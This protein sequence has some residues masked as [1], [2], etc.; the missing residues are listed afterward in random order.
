MKFNVGKISST[1]LLVGFI[2]FLAV[3]CAAF[4]SYEMSG[5]VW[6][7]WYFARIFAKTGQFVIIDRSP[8]YAL[9]LNLFNWLP[10]PVSV[11][12][13]YLVTTS[14]VVAAV[15]AFIRSYL[16]IWL[17]LFGTCLWLPFFQM[18]EPPVQKLALAFG[19]LAISIR[20]DVPTR[21]RIVLSYSLLFLA[22]LFR[23]NYIVAIA[24][25][26]LFDAVT[27]LRS[28]GTASCFAWRPK[29]GSDWPIVL[30]LALYVWFLSSQTTSP[31]SNVWFST[32]TWFP[33]DGKTMANGGATQCFNWVYILQKY[34][35]FKDHDFYFTNKEVF[36]GQTSL[37]GIFKANPW[38]I[39]QI[40]FVN[41]KSLFTVMLLG[42]ELPSFGLVLLDKI[43]K[44][45]MVGAIFYGAFRG[46]RD[47]SARIFIVGCAAM[48]ATTTLDLP[49]TR[50]MFPMIP[51][52]IMAISWYSASFSNL[53]KRHSSTPLGVLKNMGLSL[54]IF[55]FFLLLFKYNSPVASPVG[56]TE[57][58]H[59]WGACISFLGAI[60]LFLTSHL[61][62]AN[63][64]SKLVLNIHVIPAL[65][66]LCYFSQWN[67]AAWAEVDPTRGLILQGSKDSMKASLP[68]IEEK[69]ANC[70]GVMSLEHTFFGAFLDMPMDRIFDVW[71]IPPFGTLTN[72]EYSG[73][74]PDRID[75]V[76][77]SRN[78]AT[79]FGA[80]TNYQIRYQNYIAPYI[81]ELQSLGAV[82]YDIP[83]YGQAT[84]LYP[85]KSE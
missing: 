80:G 40:V 67:F 32:T 54:V 72:S 35:T 4:G 51:L 73:L 55:G 49:K 17:A 8:L 31:W 7:Y 20:N 41:I 14:M 3:C 44:L 9:Y 15:I 48:L 27:L 21:F 69:V 47:I 29:L 65:F 52:F 85:K 12:L 83:Q 25:F 5:E 66:M 78:L 46:A 18:A 10:Y 6:G 30:V 75:C 79:G 59:F 57:G 13:E 2:A 1:Y 84:I 39:S 11:T 36:G 70:K 22:Y 33:G 63:R 77:V 56:F 37:L 61:A 43:M 19:L 34:G 28:K 62:S 23:Q 26:L 76:L 68:A 38:L 58:K 71:E 64:Q 16:G 24:P 82:T 53:L 45:T 60:V 81:K 74:R 42:S 50:Y